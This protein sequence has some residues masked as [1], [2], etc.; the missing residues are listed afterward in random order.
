MRE[1]CTD[2][3]P[4]LRKS[5]KPSCL[6]CAFF[7]FAAV[8]TFSAFRQAQPQSNSVVS[9][10][11]LVRTG[12]YSLAVQESDKALQSTPEDPRLFTLKAIALSKLGQFSEALAGFQSALNINSSYLPALAGAAELKYQLGSGDAIVYLDRLLKIKPE[13]QVAHA[14]RAVV[15][16]KAGDCPVAVEHFAKAYEQIAS[17]AAALHEYGV[18]LIRLKRLDAASDI[19]KRWRQLEPGN[20]QA[21]YALALVQVLNKEYK[22]AIGALEPWLSDANGDSKAWE[23]ASTAYEALGDTPNAVKSL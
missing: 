9:I 23:L 11:A 3:R 20:R 22:D 13:D 2:A 19:F 14:M 10:S 6:F 12:Q 4:M 17:Q 21:A 5:K 16:W 1:P 7:A 18:C 8:L 15:A